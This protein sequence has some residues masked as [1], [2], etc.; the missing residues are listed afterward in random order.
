MNEHALLRFGIPALGALLALLCLGL[1]LRA[2]RRRR[3]IDN[4]PT[5][6]TTGV[7]I[8]L[9][10]LK[11]TAEAEQP[12]LSYLAEY[13]C[14]HY[15]YTIE[16]HWSRT[17]TETYTDSHGKTRTRTRHESGWTTV[18][19]GGEQTPFYLQDDCGIIRVNPAQATIEPLSVFDATCG[20]YDPFYYGKGPAHAVGDSDHRRR[21]HET[22]IPL[23][24]SIYIV[25]SARER[26]DIVAPEIAHHRDAPLFLVSTRSEKQV[27]R[28]YKVQFWL[29]G[30]L[31]LLPC[32]GAWV[33]RAHQL[34]PVRTPNV[35]AY[36]VVGSAY[37]AVWL[38][39]WV[40]MV[41]N[42]MVD[43]RQRVRQA[44]SNVDVQL[45][46]R[47][48]LIPNLVRVVEGLRDYECQVQTELAQLR[49]QLGA[50]APGQSGPD[51]AGCVVHVNAVVE[52]YPELRANEVFMNLQ[53]NL[54]DTE[55]RLALARGY[56]NDV[57]T[58]YNT[59]LEVLPDRYVAA[60]SAMKPQPL[61]T[62]ADFERAAVKANLAMPTA[63]AG[64]P[65][66]TA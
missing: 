22:A 40:W 1:A 34:G 6:K 45:K 2:G 37:L 39:G 49:A 3:L 14:V 16:E 11:G 57:A 58:F 38:L 65:Q 30:L 19:S 48:D 7:F 29:L 60:L 42:S 17:V 56:F 63:P 43:L 36:I 35:L 51:P 50:T 28:G 18:A 13:P 9:V 4:L 33:L 41:Y 59:R 47:N 66:V 54:V 62:A 15:A 5:S 21:F 46:R 61:I 20:P 64:A 44:W 24:T 12:L 55:Q 25:G 31:G 8:G 26:D 27:S 52:R 32:V 53:K 23:H 10:E